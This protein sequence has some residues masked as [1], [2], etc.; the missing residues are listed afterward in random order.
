MRC[1]NSIH[2]V[3]SNRRL[4]SAS[5]SLNSG[6]LQKCL[7]AIFIFYG[8]SMTACIQIALRDSKP[9][10]AAGAW[11]RYPHMLCFRLLLLIQDVATSGMTEMPWIGWRTE[12]EPYPINRCGFDLSVTDTISC[13]S[14]SKSSNETLHYNSCCRPNYLIDAMLWPVPANQLTYASFSRVIHDL[15]IHNWKRYLKIL[16]GSLIIYHSRCSNSKRHPPEQFSLLA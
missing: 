10:S 5:F 2:R 4:S 6:D 11:D 1:A 13:V 16:S 9:A 14:S 8:W 15:L 12:F 3:S 7:F